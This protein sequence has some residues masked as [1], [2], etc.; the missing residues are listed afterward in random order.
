V[1]FKAIA[2]KAIESLSLYSQVNDVISRDEIITYELSIN[3]EWLDRVKSNTLWFM[4]TVY[5]GNPDLF[6]HPET[7]P[8]EL[9]NYKWNSTADD[10]EDLSISADERKQY[11]NKKFY[12]R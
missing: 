10:A 12:V 1:K 9:K 4:L 8:A 11:S 7:L 6:V 5:S 2:S 3:D